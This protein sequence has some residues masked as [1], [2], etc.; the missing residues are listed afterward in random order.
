MDIIQPSSPTDIVKWRQDID[1]RIAGNEY[2]IKEIPLAS[3]LTSRNTQSRSQLDRATL[4]RYTDLRKQ[5]IK[6]PPV[7]LFYDGENHRL[8]DGYHRYHAEHAIDKTRSIIS[9]IVPGSASD[10]ILYSLGVNSA[11][12]LPRKDCDINYAVI[13]FLGHPEW[14]KYSNVQSGIMCGCSESLVR[15]IKNELMAIDPIKP[16]DG[17]GDISVKRGLNTEDIKRA[18]ENLI[19]HNRDAG[20]MVITKTGVQLDTSKIG[21]VKEPVKTQYLYVGTSIDGLMTGEIC[22]IKR[23]SLDATDKVFVTT[24]SNYNPICILRSHLILADSSND[25]IRLALLDCCPIEIGSKIRSTTTGD[26]HTVVDR[27]SS[28]DPASQMWRLK[29]RVTNQ[30]GNTFDDEPNN[31]V[32]TEVVKVV[33]TEI[34]NPDL[35]A[36]KSQEFWDAVPDLQEPLF[37]ISAVTEDKIESELNESHGVLPRTPSLATPQSLLSV[38]ILMKP[39]L[40]NLVATFT[41]KN[42]YQYHKLQESIGQNNLVMSQMRSVIQSIADKEGGV[43]KKMIVTVED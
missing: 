1:N 35:L 38:Y 24:Q 32:P 25:A 6:L 15:K 14:I 18:Y 37:E 28:V 26:V 22:Q 39:E 12:G 8:T 3:I 5:L 36:N 29:L 13:S 17:I 2:E 10:A 23:I 11:H 30:F 7:I 41:N 21:K 42:G 9:I 20:G 40:G 16:S 31:F 19:A 4:D 27:I 34:S 33:Q 43:V